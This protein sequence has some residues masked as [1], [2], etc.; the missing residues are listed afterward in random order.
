MNFPDTQAPPVQ[1]DYGH[2]GLIN[3]VYNAIKAHPNPVQANA[4][5]V[6]PAVFF[7]ETDE[8]YRQ[9]ITQ[10]N[11]VTIPGTDLPV[12]PIIG[13]SGGGGGSEVPVDA[14]SLFATGDVMWKPVS[15]TKAGWVRC[16]GRTI[17]SASSGA[18][19]RANADCEHLYLY[20]WQTYS[21]TLC[22]VTGGRGASAA[23]DWAADKPMAML[24]LRSKAGFGLDDMGNSAANGFSGVTF[25]LGNATTAASSGG[26]AM[27][28]T[29]VNEMPSH[30][31]ALTDPGHSHSTGGNDTAD[32]GSGK[33]VKNNTTNGSTG[34]STTGIT[35]AN[36]GG[37]AAHPNMP[38]FMLG[39]WY[40][41][42]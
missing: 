19:E 39:T 4:Y 24:D 38:P 42:L 25:A 40:M 29:T 13:P 26:T 11:G 5:G 22:P 33:G 16:N 8:F 27:H 1:P 36:T 30:G 10:S 32:Q 18:A 28:T 17:G 37:G 12:L 6:F 23:A 41:R 7:D 3:Q 31:H 35:L 20:K 21:N 34:T 15:G 9:I 14:N 2:G